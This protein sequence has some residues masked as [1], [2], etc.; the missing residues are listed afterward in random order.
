[1]MIVLITDVDAE[2]STGTGKN[3]S[4][5]AAFFYQAEEKNVYYAAVT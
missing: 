4:V 5:T 3:I 1:M 2:I